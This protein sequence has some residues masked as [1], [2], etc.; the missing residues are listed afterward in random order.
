MGKGEGAKKG[1]TE[2]EEEGD[3][4][5]SEEEEE[6]RTEKLFVAFVELCSYLRHSIYI[7][8]TS[9]F[10]SAIRRLLFIFVYSTVAQEGEPGPP[11][12][13]IYVS[14]AVRIDNNSKLSTCVDDAISV[15]T[16][17]LTQQTK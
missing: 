2:N 15:A 4:P 16:V 8:A 10:P 14:G 9:T 6:K 3:T 11:S 13:F 7:I 17:I 5:E 1:I 12:L